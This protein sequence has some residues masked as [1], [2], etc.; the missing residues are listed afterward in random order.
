MYLEVSSLIALWWCVG[1][2]IPVFIQN[3]YNEREKVELQPTMYWG[4]TVW[5]KTWCLLS[6]NF[7]CMSRRAMDCGGLDSN[8]ENHNQNRHQVKAF[9][10]AWAGGEPWRFCGEGTWVSPGRGL[11]SFPKDKSLGV[12]V[13][14]LASRRQEKGLI[15]LCPRWSLT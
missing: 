5:E 3:E 4:S 12:L 7:Y 1:K 11:P 9:D 14:G 13:K 15:N 10:A 8:T 6:R 2:T